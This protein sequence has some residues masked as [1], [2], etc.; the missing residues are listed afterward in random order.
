MAGQLIY[1]VGP[2]GSGKDSILREL[3]PRLDDKYIIL[4]RV[5][6]RP[7]A[8]ATEDFES[9]RSA[10]FLEQES[11]SEFSLSWRANHL[12]YAVRTELDQQL[13]LGKT[14]IINGSREHWP[15]V[16]A[17]YPSAILVLVQVN[18]AL[19]QQR[20]RARGRE[21]EQDIQ[22]RLER[23]VSLERSLRDTAALQKHTFWIIDNS[24]DLS[25]AVE[26]FHRQLKEI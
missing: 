14:V 1:L 6:T 10:D 25:T 9:L 18:T 13:A 15:Q 8:M 12:A 20:L 24:N 21:S 23:N 17:R 26:A 3:A 16:I 19:L 22:L 4:K 2:S 7:P 5:I 11:N